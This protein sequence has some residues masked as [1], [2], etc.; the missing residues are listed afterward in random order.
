MKNI[1][2]TGG[3]GFIGVNTA[4]YFAAKGYKV[5]ILDNCSRRGAEDNIRWLLSRHPDV[6]VIRIDIVYDQHTLDDAAAEADA[7]IHLAGQVAVTTSVDRK[8]VV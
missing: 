1:L 8:S 3:A 5:T 4:D 6:K 7:I 2:I